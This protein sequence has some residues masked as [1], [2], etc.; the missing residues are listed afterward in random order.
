MK[1]NDRQIDDIVA[2]LDQFMSQNGGHMEIRVERDGANAA[3]TAAENVET[4]KTEE[5]V[6]AMK[7]AECAEAVEMA[8]CAEAA[9]SAEDA[10]VVE[11]ADTTK[12]WKTVMTRR[13]LE[14]GPGDMA[15]AVPTLFEGLDCDD[16]T[17]TE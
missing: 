2:M 15:C 12:I 14:C 9:E 1:P 5:A 4:V 6:E 8:E 11:T 3:E 17:N 10:E 7:T 16:N 13:T